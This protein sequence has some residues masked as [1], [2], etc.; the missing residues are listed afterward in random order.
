MKGTKRSE[1]QGRE[2]IKER[3]KE[4]KKTGEEGNTQLFNTIRSKL[5]SLNILI[6][7]TIGV[8]ISSLPLWNR[9]VKNGSVRNTYRLIFIQSCNMKFQKT[10]NS[11]I[12]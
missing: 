7:Y 3:E 2:Y 5:S 11:N 9:D 10:N 4:K 6:I 8:L 12:V 1:A